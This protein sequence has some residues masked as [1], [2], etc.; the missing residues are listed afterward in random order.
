MIVT[1]LVATASCQSG[2]TI[3]TNGTEM[4]GMTNDTLWNRYDYWM[5]TIDFKYTNDFQ[6]GFNET[7][8]HWLYVNNKTEADLKKNETNFNLF[9]ADVS[10][11]Y[12][13]A[14]AVQQAAYADNT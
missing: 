14:V 9:V 2:V 7:G 3:P 5:D 1:M 8:N 11:E 4:R 10:Q 12:A 6:Q 13:S